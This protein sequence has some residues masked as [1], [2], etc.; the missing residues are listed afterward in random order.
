M[1]P[2]AV[3]LP[4]V[5]KA[6]VLVIFAHKK[7]FFSSFSIWC[8]ASSST[9]SLLI[10][11]LSLIMDDVSRKE[12]ANLKNQVRALTGALAEPQD[13]MASLKQSHLK[14]EV[15]RDTKIDKKIAA[16]VKVHLEP[17]LEGLQNKINAMLQDFYDQL[18]KVLD[19]IQIENDK[20]SEAV[21]GQDSQSA[22]G[23]QHANG[24]GDGLFD[25][26]LKAEHQV[27]VALTSA[28]DDLSGLEFTTHSKEFSREFIQD[29]ESSRKALKLGF[30]RT[31]GEF[32]IFAQDSEESLIAFH[33]DIGDPI[34]RNAKQNL[35]FSR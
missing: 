29:L 4:F 17:L 26:D 35:K 31:R 24:K 14:E 12:M 16:Q 23:G 25:F 1:R 9:L 30:C 10:H 21:C 7:H 6:G 11:L 2:E 19:N 5:F 8:V 20:P 28:I 34:R 33:S 32:P 13:G 27:D 18:I 15:Q 22:S 3:C